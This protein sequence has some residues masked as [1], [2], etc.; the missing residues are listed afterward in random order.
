MWLN[1]MGKNQLKKVI[2][3]ENIMLLRRVEV[4]QI[5]GLSRSSIYRLMRAGKFPLPIKIGPRATRWLERD[6]G[7]WIS[8]R[9]RATGEAAEAKD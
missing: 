8:T 1:G 9:P 3:M 2:P 4:E 5:C 7:N 6:I